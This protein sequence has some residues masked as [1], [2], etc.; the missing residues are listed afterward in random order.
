MYIS[1]LCFCIYF[2][3]NVVCT[4]VP[5]ADHSPVLGFSPRPLVYQ[6]VPVGIS[7]SPKVQTIYMLTNSPVY[8]QFGPLLA[9]DP[10]LSFLLT[11]LLRCPTEITNVMC[12]K[13]GPQS[14]LTPHLLLLRFSLIHENAAP[15]SQLLRPNSLTLSRIPHPTC[16][17]PHLT[18]PPPPPG[19]LQVPPLLPAPPSP[20]FSSFSAQHHGSSQ[21]LSSA[22][23]RRLRCH[24]ANRA[25]L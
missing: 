16:S 17:Q 11:P 13:P 22:P 9:P 8:I 1:K 24:S 4:D 18:A 25:L 21:I 5:T 14:P 6:L 2:C 19:V 3:V 20:L 12:L 10:T 7:T 15:V 23:G